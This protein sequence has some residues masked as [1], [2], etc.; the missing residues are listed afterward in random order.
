M[1]RCIPGL[2]PEAFTVMSRNQCSAP[3]LLSSSVKGRGTVDFKWEVSGSSVY[4]ITAKGKLRL[5]EW[6]DRQPV[7]EGLIVKCS[8]PDG[9]RQHVANLQ[10]GGTRVCKHGAAALN[11]VIDA[12]AS[13]RLQETKDAAIVEQQQKAR[14]D[15]IKLEEQRQTQDSLLPGERER[16]EHGLTSR[17][18]ADIVA[19]LLNKI[20]SVEGLRAAAELFSREDMPPPV[21][22]RCRRCRKTYDP[23]IPT[24]RICRVPH[25]EDMVCREW[26]GSKQSWMEC[27]ACGKTFD[28]RGFFVN[29]KR[30]RD[31]PFDEGPYCFEGEHDEI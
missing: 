15:V 21:R 2:V 30:R 8:C 3:T 6:K 24:Q 4:E 16:L 29:G 13:A 11:S 9:L 31:D 14:K 25:P 28:L 12:A 22:R 27:A 19:I 18:P 17:Q 5:K 1:A 26:E 10:D 7:Y 20:E 23:Q